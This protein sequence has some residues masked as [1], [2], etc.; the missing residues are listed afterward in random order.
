MAKQ[1]FKDIP[2]YDT[3]E[4]SDNKNVRAKAY[5]VFKGTEK[6]YRKAQYKTPN[7]K[8]QVYVNTGKY[9]EF[10]SVDYLYK[11]TFRND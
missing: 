8:G 3:L 2:G 6:V 4:I 7:H 9:F 1:V 5:E 11:I 10:I